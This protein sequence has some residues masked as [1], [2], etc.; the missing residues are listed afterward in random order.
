[1]TRN[2][3]AQEINLAEKNLLKIVQDKSFNKEDN[4]KGLLTYVDQDELHR[5]KTKIIKRD[6]TEDFK[7][8]MVLPSSH[9]LVYDN[10]SNFVG[11]N[12]L[13]KAI[14]WNNTSDFLSET[15]IRQKFN[16]PTAKAVLNSRP[17]TYLSEYP[18]DLEPLTP[19]LFI[20]DIKT[21]VLP[22]IDKV[23]LS[24]RWTYRH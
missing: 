24:K 7:C 18:T 12:R 23:N 22:N 14:D 2:L 20:Q 5:L 19:L 3:T 21:V 13:L 4:L 1:M 9:K 15:R 10:G 11:T 16:S 6:N 8:S 17:L